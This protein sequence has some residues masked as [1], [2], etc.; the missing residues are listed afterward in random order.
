MTAH[1]SWALRL[2]W[3]VTMSLH[4]LT[5]GS[6]YDYLI[7]QVS[8]QDATDRGYSSLASYYTE[9]GESPGRWIGTG[10][11]GIDGL[12]EGDIVTADHMQAL[13]GSGHHPLAKERREQLE[14]GASVAQVREATRLG[15]PY[16]VFMSE[17]PDYQVEV[18]RQLER[19]NAK[20]GRTVRSPVPADVRAAIRTDVAREYF[21]REHGRAPI[22]AREVAATI[23]KHSRP[24]AS[25][26]AGYDLTFSP[27][28]S[29]ST[30]WAIA[31]A[32]TAAAI[33]HAHNAAVRE[34]LSFIENHALYSREG[35]N[36]ARQVDVRGL[37]ATAFTHRD[38]RAGDPDLHTHVAVANKVQ[39][40]SGKWLA[41]DGRILFKAT[42]A[43]SETYNTTLERLLNA[44]LGVRFAER[45][46]ED[47]RRRPVR[48][49][50]GVSPELN[51]LWSSRRA[52]IDVRRAEL[53]AQFQR[54]HGRPPTTV[55]AVQLAQQATLETRDAKHEPRTLAE[56]RATWRADAEK[57]L[58]GVRAVDEMID[59]ALS[60]NGKPDEF[61]DARWVEKT[62]LA[63]VNRVQQDRSTWQEWHIRAEAQRRI[64]GASVPPLQVEY[65]ADLL[66]DEALGNHSIRLAS[67]RD[68]LVEPAVLRRRDGQSVYHVAGSD[69]YTSSR[70]LDAERRIVDA[71]GR[72]DGRRVHA[73][74]VEL[75]LMESTA[76]G[77][78]L[79]AGQ[80]TMVRSMATSGARVQLG[81]AAAGT[82]KTTA[83]SVLTRA[84]EEAGGN[85][86]GLAP[87]AAAAAQLKAHTGDADTLAKLVDALEE[88]GRGQLPD[89]IN[90]GTLVL[91]DE[92][93]MADTLSLDR[94]LD[95][96]LNKGASVRLI[97]DDQQL[98]SIGAGGALRDI[99][100]T[101]GALRL[102]E[103]MRFRDPAEGAA[104]LA[105]RNGMTEALGFYLDRERIHVGDLTTL[106]DD[107]FSAW[108]RDRLAGSDSIMLAPTR[109]LV[110]DLNARAREARLAVCGDLPASEARLADGNAA[111]VGDVVITRRNDRRLRISA[112]D[113]V[114][115]GDRWTVVGVHAG[116]LAVRHMES[117]LSLTLPA[118]YVGAH[119]ELGYAT[120]VHTAQGVSVDTMHGL[121]TGAEE[122]QQLYTM[123]TRGRLENHVY[124]VMV[125]DGDE[126]DVVKP[127]AVQP[128][129]ATDVLE[130]I[131]ARD[132]SPKSATTTAREAAEPGRQLAM[133]TSRYLDALNV[134]A[135]DVVGASRVTGLENLAERLVPGIADEP[136]WPVLRAH[137][138]L[139]EAQGF[140]AGAALARA[141][142]ER[143][144]DGVQDR[145]ALLD[146]RLDPTGMR[147][148]DAGPLP[149]IPAVP[150]RVAE[151][152][153]WGLYLMQR[154][155]RVESLADRVREGVGAGDVP[156]WARQGGTRPNGE[157]LGDVA[158]WRAANEVE[159]ADRR[160]T[161]RPQLQKA[162]ARHQR[163]LD[164]RINAGRS[165]AVAE[166]GPLLDEIHPRHDAFTAV[167]AER[168]AAVSRSGVDAAVL[169]RAAAA[170]GP[171][172]D[173]HVAA[174]LWWRIN[175]H[176][177]PAVAEDAAAR[178]V[179]VETA[180]SERLIDVVGVDAAGQIEESPWWPTLVAALDKAAAHGWSTG[181]L[182]GSFTTTDV[183]D[184]DPAQAMVWKV[185]LLTDPLKPDE[186]YDER[187]T[188]MPEDIDEVLAVD[189]GP[190]DGPVDVDAELAV[191]ARARE[192][193]EPLEASEGQ[194][195]RLYDRAAE[196]A[197]SPVGIDR[198]ME[199]NAAAGDFYESRYAG[200]WAELHLRERFNNS[201][202]GDPRFRPGYAPAG[203]THLVE[204]LRRK[205]FTD[206]ELLAAGLAST[207]R[208]GRL[209]D[210]F[211]D[212][213]VLPILADGNTLG[214]VG[215]RDPGV[216]DDHGAKYLNT[217]D[218]IAFT[219][220]AQLYGIADESMAIGSIP[221]VVEGPLDAI[222][223]TLATAGAFIG[224]APLGTAMTDEQAA[225]L[226]SR[227]V[228]PIVATDGDLAG[229]LAAERNYWLLTQHGLAPRRVR[230]T[231]GED[232][233]SVVAEAGPAELHRLLVTS[234]PLSQ[235][236]A[237]ERLSHITDPGA[238]AAS[239]VDVVAAMQPSQWP[240]AVASVVDATGLSEADVKRRLATAADAFNENRRRFANDHASAT[241]QVRKRL[242]THQ[243]AAPADK[244]AALARRVDRRLL[245]Q[246]D[247]P[248][249][250]QML[251]DLDIAGV[252]V[253]RVVM[254][255][256]AA[257][258]LGRTAAQDLRYRLVSHLPH[259]PVATSIGH[260]TDTNSS[261]TTR[262]DEPRPGRAR[263][264]PM[265]P[266]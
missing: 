160:P 178:N 184:V 32:P 238:A 54:D 210:R 133:A 203:W 245:A 143:D 170:E 142:D 179:H 116:R 205:G 33:E 242:E 96:L 182:L 164:D 254:E 42:V 230:F 188:D 139:T 168:L 84:W 40:A 157:L 266:R 73:E 187:F 175:R 156:L 232:P 103:L 208:T 193:L 216:G 214:F 114:K 195:A 127:A 233:A 102:S 204:H 89:R 235:V 211:R 26:V 183:V 55:E 20:Q 58:G 128:Q 76:N 88:G 7:R 72:F 49:I 95:Y 1:R 6:G 70:I 154:S 172:P 241:S 240:Q 198:V 43:A 35:T 117:G 14:A 61:V 74:V 75:A 123:M 82:G 41:I 48:E 151:D 223:V 247:W 120:T 39:T 8:V 147:G 141:V 218:T 190:L 115:N 243:D 71:A 25:A 262:S 81:I 155:L 67:D 52:S 9:R 215:R 253:P 222:A 12:A 236:L 237:D 4:K 56:Q 200:S 202:A 92:A 111:S 60:P 100:Q 135:A 93:G 24:R 19:W 64:R 265:P 77:V 201:L 161:G 131:L 255:T 59:R 130:D 53:A 225:Q 239:A 228:D 125:G 69:V 124:L 173:D 50:V 221:V 21:E 129:T 177:S 66:V 34:A 78:T 169:L 248:A 149:W 137:L 37:V 162:P 251:Q 181:D 47:L 80:A 87:S 83:M 36:G 5:A 110:H 79:N 159:P 23:A 226:A 65:L 3:D 134:A 209:I 90:A 213:L 186:P 106:T 108:Q 259:S 68:P 231:A 104:T 263:R 148:S 171:L 174:A 28:K 140:D 17:A 119:T 246:R 152:P 234:A 112:S 197:Y 167:L 57:T 153:E 194:I 107:V 63:I 99:D 150:T 27:V 264:A 192:F 16:K 51:A 118:E 219:K 44:D 132:G 199:A 196:A 166:W 180:W 122:R 256:V 260:N 258:P 94:V 227:G 165:P 257:N 244:W 31:D 30:L 212:R 207:A 145:A 136:A 38:S 46:S 126:H 224:T 261:R 97:G 10:M 113:W 11:V 220:G 250:A 206:D 13:F 2:S 121:V 176:L 18:A 229:Y 15:L 217:S 85:V 144:L 22:D 146:W 91:L 252:D 62:A 29:V 138:L 101:H 189:D 105:L 158:V 249:T 163:R 109:D 86:L 191:I 45:P 185:S 98:A